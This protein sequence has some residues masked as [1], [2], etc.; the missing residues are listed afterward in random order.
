MTQKTQIYAKLFFQLTVNKLFINY[1]IGENLCFLRHLRSKKAFE[2][3][4]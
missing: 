4:A 2:T 1:K 3:A